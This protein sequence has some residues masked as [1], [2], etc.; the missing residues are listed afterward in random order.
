MSC[1]IVLQS[2]R[3][4][5][6]SVK[7][8]SSQMQPGLYIVATPIGS[9]RD[10]TLRALDTLKAADLILCEDTRVTAKL[11]SH[12]GI[13]KPTLSYNDHNGKERRPKIM[14]MLQ[15]GKCLALVSDAGTPLISDPGYK[16]AREVV[17]RGFY[18]TALPG[19][20]SVLAG[21][22]LSGLPTDRF[23]FAGFLPAKKEACR[24]EVAALAAVPA[25]LIFF[26]SARRLP[27]TLALL[28]EGLGNRPAAVARELTKLY[29][30]TRRG[31]LQELQAHYEKTGAPKGEVVIVIAPPEKAAISDADIETKLR[32]LLVSHSVKEAATILA[33]Q[34]GRPRKEIYAL[35]L[36]L[37]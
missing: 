25:T 19:A 21:L 20:S 16:L 22:C 37:K 12:Y 18:I 7:Q 3:Q 34:T 17:E 9:L 27:E 15:E 28:N 32:F 14:A 2:I 4:R 35:A 30:E 1:G 6:A 11:L 8:D 5:D 26:E 10:M 13:R 36:K 23:F 29:E 31:A 24:K 33:E